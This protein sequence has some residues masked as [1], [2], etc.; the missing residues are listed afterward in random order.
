M[1]DFV[2]K[3]SGPAQQAPP[4]ALPDIGL[5]ARVG[6]IDWTIDAQGG[7]AGATIGLRGVRRAPAVGSLDA[8]FEVALGG[9]VELWRGSD[10]V[11]EGVI[12]D[13]DLGNGGVP[14]ALICDGYQATLNDDVWTRTDMTSQMTAGQVLRQGI[15][16]LAPWL[17]PGVV[18]DQWIDPQIQHPGGMSDFARMSVWQMA[19]QIMKDGDTRGRE[20]WVM[21]M[22]G[23][24]VWMIPRVAPQE[25]HYLMP[26]D[27]RVT[28][29][30][31]SRRGMAAS[32]IVETGSGGS[33][34]ITATA[35]TA[36]FAQRYGFAPRVLVST[37]DRTSNAAIALR[38]RE[39]TRRSVPFVRAS[40]AV[41]ADRRTWLTNRHGVPV[42]FWKPTPGEWVK[43]ASHP[44][45]PII[46][47][48]VDATAGSATY[49]LGERDPELPKNM[50]ISTRD[51]I[52]R[53]Q[54]ML[55][56]TGGRTR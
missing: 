36:G 28:R 27:E 5:S 55:S 45:L 11:Y 40:I 38:N 10:R 32:V 15:S 8:S 16:D 26:F 35:T 48:R 56:M 37:G 7:M 31:V 44:L 21:V 43:I 50:W 20:V 46:S 1:S 54:Q 12:M 24:Q 49:E 19:D 42:P 4:A 22:P 30:R 52:A 41:T 53:Q 2:L 9:H 51:A 34:A 47:V 25:P 23:R 33:T 13:Y 18:G 14:V 6:Q 3:I 39:L 17:R 29:W